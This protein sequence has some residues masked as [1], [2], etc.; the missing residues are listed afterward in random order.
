[1]DKS[2]NQPNDGQSP[3]QETADWQ[4]AGS[5]SAEMPSTVPQA[6]SALVAASRCPSLA[7]RSLSHRAALGP[8][9]FGLVY[10]ARDDQLARHV[11][12]KVPHSQARRPAR[13][14]G[15]V[16]DGSPHGR[17]P[18]PSEHRAGVR[19]WR[20]GTSSPASS[21]PSSSTAPISPRRLKRSRLP[22][23]EAADLVATVAEALHH[24]H[25]QG[26]VHRDIK[27]GNILLDSSG[28]PFVADFGLALREEDSAGGPRY[29]GT[30]AYMSPEQARGEGH[31]VDGRSRH[32]QPGGRALRAAGRQAAVP[33]ED[34]A[35]IA[36]A[37]HHA[38]AATASAIDDTIPERVGT[39]L[40]ARP[41]R[42]GPRNGTRRPRIWPTTCGTF[43]T[44]GLHDVSSTAAPARANCRGPLIRTLAADTSRPRPHHRP[45]WP[46]PT[47]A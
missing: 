41:C 38:R 34:E 20:H 1:M 3:Q 26:L 30:P 29:A 14:S 27:P 31:R 10:L 24:A 7:H 39:H 13:R 6:A 17:Q 40:P 22:L 2:R 36:R 12:I 19:H 37:D 11:A 18:G 42:N 15:C 21:F 43:A 45:P 9:G 25:K 16:S 46:R 44:K 32:F 4:L 8:G 35:R 5:D 33:G 28:K 23:P 47:A